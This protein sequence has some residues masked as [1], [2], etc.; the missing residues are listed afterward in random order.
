MTRE[1]LMA[2]SRAVPPMVSLSYRDLVVEAFVHA[3]ESPEKVERAV[4]VFAPGARIERQELGGHFGQPLTLLHAREKEPEAIAASLAIVKSAVGREVARTAA[5]R[6]DRDLT[7]HLRF[8]K[9]AAVAGKMR[10]EG[11]RAN[12]IVKLEVRLRG[13]RLTAEQAI[14]LVEREFGGAIAAEEE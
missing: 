6:I 14:A 13:S 3:T 5:R 2:A 1:N 10:L 8:D 12:D 4:A 11:G 7:L 9:Q